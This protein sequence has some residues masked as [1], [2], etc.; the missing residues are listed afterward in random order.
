MS[1]TTLY[2]KNMVCNRCI[3][4]VQEVL[5]KLDITPLNVVLGEAIVEGKLDKEK[6]QVI[7]T[8]LKKIGFELIDDKKSRII[9]SIKTTIIKLIHYNLKN[10]KHVN[11]S[12]FLSKEI[13]YAY[14]YLSNVFSS[15][16]GTTI[17][18][19]IINQKVE[20][21]KEL[22]IY[23]ELSLKEIAYQMGYSSVQH[24]S[25]QFKKVTGFSPSQLKKIQNK[26]RKTLDK[27]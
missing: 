13:G 25:G 11:H 10:D 2:I 15:V 20:R 16:E 5:E 6:I 21:I 4:A 23:D 3:W 1:N 9:E 14:S 12:D 7:G 18:K 26:N 19:Y 22:L 24:L 17:E 8:A 27:V